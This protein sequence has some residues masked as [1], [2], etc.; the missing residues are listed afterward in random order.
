M[1]RLSLLDAVAL[2]DFRIIEEAQPHQESVLDVLDTAA[3]LRFDL[4]IIAP[5]RIN[6]REFSELR[7]FVVPDQFH[8]DERYFNL[9]TPAQQRMYPCSD[10]VG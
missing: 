7:R 9:L 2:S 4:Q 5:G 8:V 6:S 1:I 3:G 10:G